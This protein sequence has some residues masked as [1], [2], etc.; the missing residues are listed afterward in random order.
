M[1]W[2]REKQ[3]KKERRERSA[4]TTS[5]PLFPL[6]PSCIHTHME[7][8]TSNPCTSPNTHTKHA[9]SFQVHD[10]PVSAFLVSLGCVTL[11]QKS[12]CTKD[13]PSSQKFIMGHLI[14]TPTKKPSKCLVKDTQK[15]PYVYFTENIPGGCLKTTSDNSLSKVT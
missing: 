13:R 8:R 5:L 7:G 11:C 6:L 2:V 9:H 14:G 15:C 10:F 3:Q 4:M 1:F 12:L